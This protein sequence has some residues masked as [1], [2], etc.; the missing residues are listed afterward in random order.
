MATHS[1]TLAWKIPWTE[2]PGG[3][4]S[5]WSQRVRHDR[6]NLACV[7]WASPKQPCFLSARLSRPSGTMDLPKKCPQLPPSLT[8]QQVIPKRGLG[9][10]SAPACHTSYLYAQD[11]PLDWLCLRFQ[12]LEYWVI[13]SLSALRVEKEMAR[14]RKKCQPTPVFLPGESHGQRSLVGYSPWSHKES[15]TT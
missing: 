13:R 3:L 5:L 1:S 8:V 15:D 9:T 12:A 7:A 14:W 11:W 2:K 10:L 6:S 4:Q